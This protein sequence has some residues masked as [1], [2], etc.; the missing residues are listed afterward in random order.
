F[1]L[2]ACGKSAQEENYQGHTFP[3]SFDLTLNPS[4][5]LP[6]ASET[7]DVNLYLDKF[8]QTDEEKIRKAAELVK[9]VIASREFRDKV[10]NYTVDGEKKF[11]DNDGLT[12]EQVYQII[13]AGSEILTPGANNAMDVKL[14]LY[15]E[16]NNII[17]YTY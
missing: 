2:I 13:L 3:L 14:R 15:Y 9:R 10:L 6:F 4:T 11:F 16:R 5:G 1:S 7:F 17:G 8:N 12:N